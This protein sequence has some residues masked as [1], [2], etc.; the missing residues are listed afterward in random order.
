MA[1]MS[2]AIAL[3]NEAVGARRRPVRSARPPGCAGPDPA[4]PDGRGDPV[5]GPDRLPVALPARA[6]WD[7]DGGLGPVA[8]LAGERRLGAGDGAPR[9]DRPG[10]PRSRADPLDGDGRRPDR[11]GRPLRAD[12][13]PGRW[14]RWPHDRH[15]ADDPRRDPRLAGRRPR[16]LRSAPRRRG[17]PRAPARPPR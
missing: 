17:R 1:S 3:V 16:E 2:F 6:L 14:P 7:L 8:A 10:A 4:P 5:P 12:V 15:E 9:G 13:P 11:E